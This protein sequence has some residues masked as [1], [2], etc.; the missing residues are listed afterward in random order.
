ME[1]AET[2]AGAADLMCALMSGAT[3]CSGEA[4]LDKAA[5][6]AEVPQAMVYQLRAREAAE[7]AQLEAALA[8]LEQRLDGPDLC[9]LEA[10]IDP[11][12]TMTLRVVSLAADGSLDPDLLTPGVFEL[13]AVDDTRS[14]TEIVPGYAVFP[15]LSG[16]PVMVVWEPLLPPAPVADAEATV[17]AGG[18]VVVVAL[19]EAARAAFAEATAAHIGE[20]LAITVDNVVLMAP[21]VQEAVTGGELQINGDFTA[22]EAQRLAATLDAGSL[23]A[24]MTLEL[25]SIEAVDAR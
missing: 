7:R 1:E 10:T 23:P 12:G 2:G 3:L 22:E 5:A 11:D 8:V 16:T 13:Y 14:T 21:K 15:D 25:L 19:T 4:V 9:T 20:R 17:S 18:W 24:G 6:C